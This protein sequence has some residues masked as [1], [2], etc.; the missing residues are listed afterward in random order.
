MQKLVAFVFTSNELSEKEIKI[1]FIIT[2]KII[3]Y[4][5][6]NLTKE[7]KDLYT[8]NY[9]MLMKEILEDTNKWKDILCVNGVED[10]NC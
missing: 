10:L 5:R 6:I 3:K 2:S 9:K 8:E 4:L 1:L 7:L